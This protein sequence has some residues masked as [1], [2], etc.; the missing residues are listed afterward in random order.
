M[1]HGAH[2]VKAKGGEGGGVNQ[3]NESK[4]DHD[5]E[6]TSSHLGIYELEAE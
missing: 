3:L 6:L 1:W 2:V 5:I 4:T